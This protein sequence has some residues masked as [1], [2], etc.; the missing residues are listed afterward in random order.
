MYKS[1]LQ[2][3]GI[4][5]VCL[6]VL[7]VSAGCTKDDSGSSRTK[8]AEST[9]RIDP[10][11]DG[12]LIT[13]V[14][15]EV[16]ILTS[17]GERTEARVG[18]PLEAGLR[19]GTGPDSRCVVTI[20]NIGTFD[21]G[22]RSLVT[23]ESFYIEEKQAAL[24]LATGSVRSKIDKL[25]RRDSCLIRTGTLVAAVRGTDFTVE[26]AASGSVRVI[27]E[28]GSVVLFPPNLLTGGLH[29]SS[30]LVPDGH[31]V[32][33]ELEAN[34]ES[35]DAFLENLPALQAGESRVFSAEALETARSAAEVLASSVQ[36]GDQPLD[37]ALSTALEGITG[38]AEKDISRSIE[39]LEE[40]EL[41]PESPDPVRSSEPKRDGRESGSS[42]VTALTVTRDGYTVTIS[43]LEKAPLSTVAQ[44]PW[45][46]PLPY[47]RSP[48]GKDSGTAL[49]GGNAF[50]VINEQ[51]AGRG[52]ARLENGNAVLSVEKPF[53][54]WGLIVEPNTR[55]E[56]KKGEIYLFEFTAWTSGEIMT[57]AAGFNEGGQDLNGDGNPYSGYYW[58]LVSVTGE[59]ARYSVL[60]AHRGAYNAAGVYNVST[61]AY[62]GTLYVR[63]LSC[64]SVGSGLYTHRG[65]AGE[66]V[67]N[68]SFAYGFLFWTAA[69]HSEPSLNGFSVQDGRFRYTAAARTAERWM[70]QLATE[71][72]IDAN[73]RYRLS[74][75]LY[76]SAIADVGVD[77]KEN[78]I[79]RD[80]DGNPFTPQSPWMYVETRPGQWSRYD[81]EF[82][83]L[84][85][86]S[87][88]QLSFS[89][90]SVTGELLLDEVSLV[91]VR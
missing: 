2:A 68:G 87:E 35:F 62:P 77:F 90:G 10:V 86:N 29:P 52:T 60:Y 9:S 65:G 63:D 25:A 34:P 43:A 66:L 48:V 21:I 28:T 53:E 33:P 19:V 17:S 7:M 6:A 18:F 76:A 79:D 24:T 58:Q 51:S 64:R 15:G 70:S 16:F 59:S 80:G 50:T 27:V 11:I 91:K 20:E 57:A 26:Q 38:A 78:S 42:A 4:G 85:E 88:S 22:S 12:A 71:T 82:D 73:S 49:D 45:I 75:S 47:L 5:M 72:S 74:F 81:I 23:V 69:R 56:L 89:L 67:N 55:L 40:F 14:E 32:L 3:A 44:G 30:T 61:G 31:D 83:S 39:L 46:R 84:G 36:T 1:V 41:P 8:E 37:K 13:Y 54:S